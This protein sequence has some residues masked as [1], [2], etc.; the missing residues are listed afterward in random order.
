M[1]AFANWAHWEPKREL[2]PIGFLKILSALFLLSIAAAIGPA[3]M[4]IDRLMT[5]GCSIIEP[6]FV[7]TVCG[8]R[9]A[10]VRPDSHRLPA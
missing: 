10:D 9:A 6:R 1:L 5:S 2:M 8:K 7:W 4:P 3:S